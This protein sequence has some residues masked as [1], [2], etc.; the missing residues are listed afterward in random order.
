MIRL[1]YLLLCVFLAAGS[2]QAFSPQNV[3]VFRR[4]IRQTEANAVQVVEPRAG[5][6]GILGR[7]IDRF[8]NRIIDGFLFDEHDSKSTVVQAVFLLAVIE[9]ISD[10]NNCLEKSSVD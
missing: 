10:K 4:A 7:V 1:V 2:T 8:T 3:V 9:M 5:R 6:V